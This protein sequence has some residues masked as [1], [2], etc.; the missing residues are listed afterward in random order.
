[1]IDERELTR[2]IEK[3]ASHYDLPENG[4]RG[5]LE[6][7]GH[8]EAM[9]GPVAGPARSGWPPRRFLPAAA[10]VVA[11]FAVGSVLIGSFGGSSVDTASLQAEAGGKTSGGG[12]G[13][14]TRG[15][16]GT[17]LAD[18]SRERD[19]EQAN[20]QS[21]GGM[22]VA[23]QALSQPQPQPVRSAAASPGPAS[24]PS[25]ASA[26]RPATGSAPD[27]GARVVKTGEVQVEV[28][29]GRFGVAIERL[30]ALAAGRRGF[31][32]QTE[33]SEGDSAPNG[34]VT[35]RVPAAE[36]DAVVAEVR[37]LGKV[38]SATSRGQDV[39]AQYT[40]IEA[41]LRG[42]NASRDQILTVL[43]KATT[44][45][46]I[47]AV[48]ERLNSVQVQIEQLQGQQKVLD[49]QTTFGTVTVRV[50]EPGSDKIGGPG[51]RSGLS[52]AWDDARRG[53][54]DGLEAIVAGSGTALIVAMTL[55]AFVL[56]ARAV[57][58]VTRRRLI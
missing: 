43:S 18:S 3:A 45:G 7:A 49:D 36:F 54:G 25:P 10:A 27:S 17:A 14:A 6:A 30:T 56:A 48:Q 2:L 9:P 29:R 58:L 44:V 4:R 20:F 8:D 40:D 32:A 22:A 28:G 38:V 46:D 35:L 51:E 53:F 16:T 37:K 12:G 11:L 55:A 1:M 52:G 41:R 33:T 34:I 50:A 39:T 21:N 26:P 42:L 57:W 31:V 19:E 23:P 15:G 24:A 5:I 47:L 13:V